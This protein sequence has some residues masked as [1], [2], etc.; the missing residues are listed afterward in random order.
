ME[1]AGLEI[2][3]EG[4][5]GAMAENVRSHVSGDITSVTRTT[6]S[7]ARNRYRGRAEDQAV[8]ALRPFGHYRATATAT[9]EAL[10]AGWLLRLKV[11]PGP[12]VLV[13]DV[14]LRLSG[15]GESQAELLAWRNAWPLSEGAV[16]DQRTWAEQKDEALEI[17]SAL[18]FMEASLITSRIELDLERDR[19]SLI[20]ELATGPRSIMGE[21]V[22]EQDFMDP[23]VLAPVPRFRRGAP[24]RAEYI[25]QLRTDLWKLG[26]FE[27]IDVLEQRVRDATSPRVD[28][29]VRLTRMHRATHQG[30]IG[31]GTDT[32]F[33]T[34]YRYQHHLLSSR[35]D[36]LIAGFTWQTRNEEIQLFGEYRIPRRSSR[37][38][39]WLLNPVYRERDERFELDV[40]GRDEKLAVADYRIDDFYMRLGQLTFR[41][42]MIGVDR[43]QETLY[44]DILSERNSVRTFFPDIELPDQFAIR[45]LEPVD[46]DTIAIGVQWDW[47]QFEGRGFQLEGHRERAWLFTANEAWGSDLDFTQAY[48][49][50]R[51]N[52]GLG[53][54]WRLLLRGEV[55]YTDADVQELEIQE[56]GETF[57][58]SLTRLPSRYRFRAGGS[59]SVRGYDF[60]ELSNNGVG[61][62][63]I[64][65]A[66]VE[67]ELKL[68][69][70]WTAA[71][72]VDTGNAFND[73]NDAD[74][75]TGVGVGI[76]W[77][78]AGF[79]LRLDVA[80]ALDLDGEPWRLHFTIGSPLF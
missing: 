52:F 78:T 24:Y 42:P 62:N 11:D 1:D 79:P 53:D 26:Y 22:F 40:E 7:R 61:S 21:V 30:T 31:Y 59:H 27:T 3:I 37:V 50:S 70:A 75:S 41:N 71:A 23:R 54:R 33:R 44:V 17:A 76:R 48:L 56:G 57:V 77:Y 72:F 9:F 32:E 47:P 46:T 18:G 20:L 38:R 2:V 28:L 39:Y 12:P 8:I 58:A 64:V 45:D 15:P 10:E 4:V 19:A 49:S 55:G 66:S 68:K 25:E 60:E 74:L 16:L 14:D 43:L 35:G 6:S 65:T 5:S 51:W 36:G 29:L 80:Q 73:W 69:G 34:Q 67:V 63:H 13:K